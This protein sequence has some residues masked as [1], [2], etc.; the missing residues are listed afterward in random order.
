M[1]IVYVEEISKPSPHFIE[2][3]NPFLRGNPIHHEPSS[4]NRLWISLSRCV[5]E[6]ETPAGRYKHLLAIVRH[7]VATRAFRQGIGLPVLKRKGSE[8]GRHIPAT[9]IELCTSADKKHPI[10]ASAQCD[11]VIKINRQPYHSSFK[12]RKIN[13]NRNG[14]HL[15]L[16][17]PG[18]FVILGACI[19]ARSVSNSHFVTLRRQRMFY[20]LPQGECVHPGL[21]IDQVVPLKR[22]KLGNERPVRQVI[23][24]VT[25]WVPRRVPLVK[26]IARH[27]MQRPIGLPPDID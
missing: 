21:A 9:P 20:I 22:P 25:G 15:I 10:V 23:Q 24:I 5:V 18:L 16:R 27:L 11:I 26:E 3:L 6:I 2:N 17:N 1:H 12:T 7:G 8:L 19:V 4:R 14:F 13:S